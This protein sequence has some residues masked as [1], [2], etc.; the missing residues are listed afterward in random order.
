MCYR[1][2]PGTYI[3]SLSLTSNHALTSEQQELMSWHN[4]L[5]HLPFNK[6]FKLATWGLLPKP[7]LK[8]RDTT[9]LCVACQFGGAHRRPWCHKG[10]KS[11]S[12]RQADQTEPDDGVSVDQIVS[13]QPSLIPQM[14]GFLTSKCIWGCTT[15]VDPV[16]YYVYVH[17]TRDFTLAETLLA[18]TAWENF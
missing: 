6:I 2:I 12:I 16:T 4:R 7:L 15:V 11:G 13:A 10:R 3:Y 1:K 5:Y 9:P 17:L 18:K 8:C 14:A